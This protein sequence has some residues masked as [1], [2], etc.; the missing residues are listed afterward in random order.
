MKKHYKSLKKIRITKFGKK[1]YS[2]LKIS[3]FIGI[4]LWMIFF[5]FSAKSQT[6]S[7]GAPGKDAQWASSG[8]QGVGT[9][10]TAASKVWFTL[11]GGAMTEVYYPDVTTA[12]VHLLQ[13]IAVNIRSGKTETEQDDTIHQIKVLRNDSLSFQQINTAKSG[14][15]RITKTYA[16][17]A[18]TDTIL[19]NV[20]I[21]RF[22][23]FSKFYVYYDPSLNNSGMR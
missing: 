15:W 11:E 7:P 20:K 14:N 8:K 22:N 9:S 19:I 18:E 16:T 6:L 4:S 21:E 5:C 17:D 12:N 10:A 3:G 13:F 23:D 1:F 2:N